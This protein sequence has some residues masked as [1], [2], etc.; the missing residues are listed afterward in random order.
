M[1]RLIKFCVVF[2]VIGSSGYAEDF[3]FYCV[4]NHKDFNHLYIQD[5]EFGFDSENLIMT[6]L[7]KHYLEVPVEISRQVNSNILRVKGVAAGP[8]ITYNVDADIDTNIN[9]VSEFSYKIKSSLTGNL[10]HEETIEAS[11]HIKKKRQQSKPRDL[12]PLKP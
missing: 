9:G 12:G 1:K 2:F 7:G 5:N 6:A 4:S 11:C 10:W 8:L 3:P